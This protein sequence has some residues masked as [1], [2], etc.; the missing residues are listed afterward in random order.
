MVFE[1]RPEELF[2]GESIECARIKYKN[3][4]IFSWMPCVFRVL[5]S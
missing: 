1:E 3:L 2:H 4:M 5:G